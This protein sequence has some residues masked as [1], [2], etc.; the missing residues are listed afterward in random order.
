MHELWRQQQSLR[1]HL[2]KT[3]QLLMNSDFATI[4]LEFASTAPLAV[5]LAVA[6]TSS[7]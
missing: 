3:A 7:G 2:P 5:V 4:A 1:L 6:Q